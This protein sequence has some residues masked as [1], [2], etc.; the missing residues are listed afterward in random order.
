LPGLKDLVG[1]SA[2]QPE[3]RL[4]LQE[5][6]SVMLAGSGLHG[7]VYDV[8]EVAHALKDRSLCE[9]QALTYAS[10]GTGNGQVKVSLVA[11]C[12][13]WLIASM[14]SLPRHVRGFH[15]RLLHWLELDVVEESH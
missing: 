7:I 14:L 11:I 5:G 12:C 8:K 4:G 2:L 3:R 9:L 10:K 1:Q 13:I 6:V 15:R